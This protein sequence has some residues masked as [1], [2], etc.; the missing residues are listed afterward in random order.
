MKKELWSVVIAVVLA[1]G[2]YYLFVYGGGPM[3]GPSI[4]SVEQ[5]LTSSQIPALTGEVSCSIQPDGIYCN[6]EQTK[7]CFDGR[8]VDA[9]TG[10]PGYYCAQ[11]GCD[12]GDEDVSY[13]LGDIQCKLDRG[14]PWYY[15]EWH[16]CYDVG[17]SLDC[18]ELGGACEPYPIDGC[19]DGTVHL[20]EADF[21]CPGYG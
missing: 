21:S 9:C 3:L 7:I 11:V 8:C 10:R 20:G 2:V 13:P 18:G 1:L 12:G 6:S 19:S 4:S 14:Y 17:Q 15:A 16:C 5:R